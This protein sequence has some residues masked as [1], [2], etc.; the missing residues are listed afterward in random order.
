[1]KFNN[2]LKMFIIKIAS[3]LILFS[4]SVVMLYNVS[5]HSPVILAIPFVLLLIQ[6]YYFTRFIWNGFNPFNNIA[7]Y[8]HYL[9]GVINILKNFSIINF[10]DWL[11]NVVFGFLLLAAALYICLIPWTALFVLVLLFGGSIPIPNIMIRS[12]KDPV[13]YFDKG[14]IDAIFGIKKEIKQNGLKIP[15]DVARQ[16]YEAGYSEALSKYEDYIMN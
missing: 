8:F 4:I 3:G 9:G 5:N 15:F 14:R 2:Y 12:K 13:Y 11:Y 10:F 1:M 16:Y 6:T 7:G